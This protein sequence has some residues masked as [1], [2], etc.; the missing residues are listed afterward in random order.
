MTSRLKHIIVLIIFMLA[1]SV[2]A[3][4]TDAPLTIYSA[5]REELVAPI[6]AQFTE[7][8]GIRVEVR[9]GSL[10]EMVVTVLEEGDNSPADVFFAKDASALGALEKEDRFTP[11]PDDILQLVPEDFQSQHG[12]WVGTSGRARTVIYNPELVTADDLPT[13]L[14]DLTDD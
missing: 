7:D 1:P 6:I 12:M 4:D 8:T 3:Q 5:R 11:L 14:I 10:A 9:Y 2:F 13:S